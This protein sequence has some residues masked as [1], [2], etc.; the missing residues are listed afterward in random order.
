MR[1]HTTRFCALLVLF[2][3]AL[4]GCGSIVAS[5]LA[6]IAL[7]KALDQC[8]GLP[9]DPCGKHQL[10]AGIEC[11]TQPEVMV[12]DPVSCTLKHRFGFG[13]VFWTAGYGNILR[14]EYKVTTK[15]TSNERVKHE[16]ECRSYESK[17]CAETF[18]CWRATV[19][20]TVLVNLEIMVK[21][22]L[23]EV[24]HEQERILHLCKW[25]THP[26]PRE[27]GPFEAPS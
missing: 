12:Q 21:G 19:H 10:G 20:Q 11:P 4:C 13:G 1:S 23:T 18:V 2:Q 8:E 5:H 3:I 14:G 25:E 15:T 6:K 22:V 9:L 16:H 17:S 24:E 27:C 7:E 26:D